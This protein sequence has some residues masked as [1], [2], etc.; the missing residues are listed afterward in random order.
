[1][2]A[3]A[4]VTTRTATG[5]P[6]AICSCGWEGEPQQPGKAGRRTAYADKNRHLR[7]A[8]PRTATG[9]PE[10]RDGHLVFYPTDT[11][12]QESQ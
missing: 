10:I 5:E 12:T 2:S 7:E 11:A 1:M 6:V 9:E 3:Y 8:H 4:D